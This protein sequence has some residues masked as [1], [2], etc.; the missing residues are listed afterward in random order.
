MKKV[1][2]IDMVFNIVMQSQYNVNQ[3]MMYSFTAHVYV[4]TS[5]MH[6]MQHVRSMPHVKGQANMHTKYT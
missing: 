4:V 1:N 3:Y 6:S 2:T 5:A